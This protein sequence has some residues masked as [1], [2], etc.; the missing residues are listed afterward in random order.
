[1]PSEWGQMIKQ[2]IIELKIRQTAMEAKLAELGHAATPTGKDIYDR[3]SIFDG[4]EEWDKAHSKDFTMDLV[5]ATYTIRTASTAM[6][7]YMM[8]VDQMGLSKD[9]KKMIRELEYGAM[10]VMKAMVA[11]Q[12][13]NAARAAAGDPTAIFSL[14]AGGGSLAA[15]VAFGSK[16]QGGMV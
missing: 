8:L 12:L 5:H 4:E 16:I 15:S 6:R 14:I 11:L 9:Q 13:F 2:E 3:T 10:M 7:G 1:M